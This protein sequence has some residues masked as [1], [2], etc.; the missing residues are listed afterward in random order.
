[1][2]SVAYYKKQQRFICPVVRLDG[3]SPIFSPE[4]LKAVALY[5]YQTGVMVAQSSWE[6][7]QN[8][9]QFL[10]TELDEK[11]GCGKCLLK[12]GR[13]KTPKYFKAKKQNIGHLRTIVGDD[14]SAMKGRK[15][16][17]KKIREVN[18]VNPCLAADLKKSQAEHWKQ[19]HLWNSLQSFW[20]FRQ[21]LGNIFKPSFTIARTGILALFFYF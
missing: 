2:Q 20:A 12:E 21:G 16:M 11:R 1:M 18:A 15:V 13:E 17:G 3:I 7:G 10:L 9:V 14:E 8:F 4:L 5:R 6:A 19:C